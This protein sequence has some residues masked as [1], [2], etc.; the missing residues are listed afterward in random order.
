MPTSE[1]QITRVE[2]GLWN[3][4]RGM[5]L[6]ALAQCPE[7]FGS[8][9]AREQAFDETEWRRRA[10]RPVT[11]L[12]SRDG[13]D[14]G[15]A[16]VHEFNGSWT[17][18]GMWIAPE[19]RGT[20]VVDALM[21]ACEKVARQSGADEIVVGVMEDNRAGRSAYR[22]LGFTPTGQR[23]HPHTGRTELWLGKPLAGHGASPVRDNRQRLDRESCS[24]PE[25]PEM[26]HPRPGIELVV[27][28]EDVLDELITVATTDAA[29]D[30]VTPALGEGWTPR[31][32][33]WLRDYHR[34]R[35]TG[36]AGADEETAA[37]RVDNR[38]VGATRLHR[39]SSE[40][41]DVLV[42]GIWLARSSRGAGLS[43]SV[44]TLVAAR[45]ATLGA[46][47]LVAQTT[48]DNAP[49]IAAL[50]RAGAVIHHGENHCV[51]AEILLNGGSL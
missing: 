5:R 19:A 21:A 50:R 37:I 8:T 10:Q 47:R 45:A 18:V 30:E 2:P 48:S 43:A 29:P 4:F 38:I 34:R 26:P 33:E 13:V 11:F 41:P 23:E 16:G 12:A 7:M 28:D 31:R 36:L 35:R 39:S 40:P 1:V 14:I 32:V 3:R 44:L 42:Y 22:R 25:R 27:V 51:R 15:V 9:L 20:G 17:V 6:A 24:A 49:A 46:S